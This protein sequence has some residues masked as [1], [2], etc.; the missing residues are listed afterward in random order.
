MPKEILVPANPLTK[1]SVTSEKEK[2][3]IFKEYEEE[4]KEEQDQEDNNSRVE[5]PPRNREENLP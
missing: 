5:T 4:K 2:P 1:R 3:Q